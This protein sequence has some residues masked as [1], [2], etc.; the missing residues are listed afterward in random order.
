MSNSNGSNDTIFA[1]LRDDHEVQ[2]DLFERLEKTQGDET[3]RREGFEKLKN[4]LLNH[5]TAEEKHFYSELMTIDLT[6]EK[7][8]HSVA[9]HHE[10]DEKVEELESIDFSSSQ[11]LP[12][13]RDLKELVI[14][15]LDE[16]EEEVF[17]LAGRA[18]TEEQQTSLGKSYRQ[19]VEQLR[20]G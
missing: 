14:H 1:E 6:Q 13:L 2:R 8:R 15:H 12:K 10:I 17:P 4:E 11:W 9:E 19:E 20:K 5:E 16:E 3:A 18:L 7:T